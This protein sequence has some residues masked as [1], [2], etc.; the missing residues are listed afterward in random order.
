MMEDVLT[1]TLSFKVGSDATFDAPNYIQYY[2]KLSKCFEKSAD[3]ELRKVSFF[4]Y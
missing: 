1:F 3:P 2:N 4:S